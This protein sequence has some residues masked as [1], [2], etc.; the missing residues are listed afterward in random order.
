MIDLI[1]E[2]LCSQQQG[3]EKKKIV[4]T[5]LK[6]ENEVAVRENKKKLMLI[7]SYDEGLQKYN[8]T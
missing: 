5:A 7:F 4:K 6:A 3:T 1:T 2:C 8:T